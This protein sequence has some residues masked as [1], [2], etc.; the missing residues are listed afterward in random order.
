[1]LPPAYSHTQRAI[2]LPIIITISAIL[3][4][5]IAIEKYNEN[6]Y[7]L[8]FIVLVL[9][10]VILMIFTSSLTIRDSGNNLQ[11]FFGPIPILI[12]S[13]PYADI[14]AV[15]LDHSTIFSFWGFGSW[16]TGYLWNN[17]TIDC[18]KI[19]FGKK[20]CIIGTDDPEGLR[21]FLMTKIQRI[22]T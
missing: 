7:W 18:V 6:R 21:A 2:L 20:S 22:E 13:I 16:Q 5:F 12:K 15:E 14:V 8:L 4:T 19:T 10:L 11:V 1:M 3:N 9:F 17:G